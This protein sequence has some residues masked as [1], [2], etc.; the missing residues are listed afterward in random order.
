MVR[1][2]ELVSVKKTVNIAINY[3]ISP[4]TAYGFNLG[5]VDNS[6]HELLKGEHQ[7]SVH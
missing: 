4:F 7:G 5:I 3:C 6:F 2:S 1:N